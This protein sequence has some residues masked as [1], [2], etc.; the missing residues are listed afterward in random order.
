MPPRRAEA[1]REVRDAV[2]DVKEDGARIVLRWA[3]GVVSPSSREPS[4]VT[5]IT[6]ETY[7]IFDGFKAEEFGGN[8]QQGDSRLW[9]AAGDLGAL[10]ASVNSLGPGG[11]LGAGFEVLVAADPEAWAE[12]GDATAARYRVVALLQTVHVGGYAVLHEL[13]IRGAV[14]GGGR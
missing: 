14:P 9:V 1:L 2:A 7:G 13:H 8:V 12:T 3:R 4:T 6:H 5:P 11:Q 10:S